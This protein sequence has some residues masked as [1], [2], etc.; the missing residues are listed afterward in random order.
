M[1]LD[2][3][4]MTQKFSRPVNWK[5]AVKVHTWVKGDRNM[6]LLSR[7]STHPGKALTIPSNQTPTPYQIGSPLLGEWILDPAEVPHSGLFCV[8]ILYER[9]TV[10]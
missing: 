1:P 3:S 5:T 7:Q 8:S 10:L 9:Q 2:Y 4:W 6:L